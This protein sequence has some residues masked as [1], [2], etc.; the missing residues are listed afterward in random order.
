MINLPPNPEWAGFVLRYPG[1][2]FAAQVELP[3]IRI[4]W[5]TKVIRQSWHWY[6]LERDVE[7]LI[8]GTASRWQQHDQQGQ[9]LWIPTQLTGERK[10][11]ER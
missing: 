3:K 4:E 8:K 11:I 1:Q 10:E 7:V 9:D 5:T 6:V 2:F